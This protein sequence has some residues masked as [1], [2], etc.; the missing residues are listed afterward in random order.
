M[1]VANELTSPLDLYPGMLL[2]L[3]D[4]RP[5][6]A[7]DRL[8]R[9]RELENL[10]L[11]PVHGRITSYFGRRNL[12]L[13]SS[14]FHRGVDVAAPHGT[15]IVASRRGTVSFAG[16]SPQGYGNL[17]KIRHL[18]GAETWYAHQ[19]QILV[20]VGQFVAQGELIGRIGST[21]ISTGPHLHFELHRRGKAL[22]PLTELN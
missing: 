13:G 12:G 3:P 9:V 14:G 21:G 17:V 1:V 15:P 18:G 5:S 10:F 8:L 16:W 11:W 19:S 4:V 2:F 6:A 20:D 22:D 7:L